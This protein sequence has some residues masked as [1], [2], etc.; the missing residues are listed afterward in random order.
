MKKKDIELFIFSVSFIVLI[1]GGIL[2]TYN[3]RIFENTNLLFDSDTARVIA[4]AT[5]ITAD[6]YR[7]S[8][9][10]LFVLLIQPAVFLIQGIVLNKMMAIVILSSFVSA[11]S[12]LY[13]Y[14]ILSNNNSNNKINILLCGIYLFSF[15]NIIF[16]TGIEMYN[17]ATL[18]LLMIWYYFMKNQE[19][20]LDKYSYIILVVLG[21]LSAAITITNCVIY[22]IIIF[23]LWINKKIKIKNIILLGIA[24]VGSIITLNLAQRAIWHNTPVLIKS[25][26]SGE[27]LFVSTDFS[28]NNIKNVLVND[29]Y[30][31][32]ISNKIKLN[33][34]YDLE[35]NYDNYVIVF[36]NMSL[37]NFLLISAFYIILIFLVARN[38]KK[39]K[40]MNRGLLL[41]LLFNTGLHLIYG[42]DSPFLYSLHFTYIYLLLFG[43]NWVSEEN[44]SFKRISSLFLGL[45]FLLECI[46]NNIVFIKV[47]KYIDEIINKNYLLAE[48]GSVKTIVIEIIAIIGV[49]FI[50]SLIIRMIRVM[51]KTT[52][53]RW[54]KVGV[55]GLIF[56]SASIEMI[57][58]A[59]QTKYLQI[60]E[61]KGEDYGT[62]TVKDKT[63]YLSK[64][65]KNH[66]KNEM[67][68]VD[69]YRKELDQ[70]ESEY[71]AIPGRRVNW[72][73]Y[74]Y[75]GMANRK[76]LLYK[77]DRIIDIETKKVLY[78]FDVDEIYM[79]PNEYL[80]L[81][82]TKQKDFIKIYE[83]DIGVHININ[84]KDTI[85]KGTKSKLELY[86]FDNYKYKNT[87][88]TLYGEL[89]FNIK[90]GAIYP[91]II[92]Y[93]KPWYRDA[94]I[95]SMVLQRT[96]NT[97]LIKDWVTNITD[98]YDRQNGG[99]SE[100]D[101]LGELL[102]IL[103]TQE[104]RNEELIDKIE[105][106]ANRLAD[107][108]EDGYYIYGKTD[109]GDMY[110]Y[111]NLWY[112]LGIEAVGRTCNFDIDSIPI[113][114]YT[115]MAW[116]SD[117]EV[118]ASPDDVSYE[119]P[120]LSYATRHKLGK[121]TITINQSLYPLSFEMGASQANYRNYKR[122]DKD[123]YRLNAS[124]P[125]AW[126]ASELMLLL[127][128]ENN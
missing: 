26:P 99:I 61:S 3:Y 41:A 94:A 17:F 113:D 4:D 98:I 90:E 65:F 124:P 48:Y 82:K 68:L 128:E 28:K 50:I 53:K 2:L 127:M 80:I 13:L 108:N 116:W 122:I 43:I 75:F 52:N 119:F 91:N 12:V 107:A 67:S 125:H 96:G 71:Q 69:D 89:L 81:I 59:F 84:D 85:I 73:Y 42:N 32:L 72:S 106:E 60:L 93:D 44:R 117:Y 114:G 56:L 54:I 118:G 51:K 126:A 112:K 120:Y 15:S 31:S 102:Y 47:L 33:I 103:S 39:N 27:L 36:D 18:F 104:E 10:P 38:Y 109:F 87:L 21:I 78:Q 57:F 111:Q 101:N 25:N 7:I 5:E 123:M 9:H 1:I 49:A 115:K 55:I 92:V 30:N 74:Y 11:L 105:E 63:Y 45:F 97:V 95:T 20:K 8:V 79:V 77:D 88:K 110:L 23:I 35:Y 76:K 83:D 62:I 6:H 14:K 16:T 29:Y 19:K 100:P 46:I 24:I 40:N 64:N 22:L 37:L 66:F 58:I 86:S 34:K 70:L 121:G